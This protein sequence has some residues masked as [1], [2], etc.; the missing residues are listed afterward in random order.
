[1]ALKRILSEHMTHS[2]LPIGR[3]LRVNFG[4]AKIGGSAQVGDEIAIYNKPNRII[5]VFE[6][7]NL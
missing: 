5:N 4:K 1:M 2:C 6:I 7:I 3:F